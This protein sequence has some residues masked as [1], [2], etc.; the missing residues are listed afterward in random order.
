MSET[1]WKGRKLHFVGVGGSGMSGYARAAHT[2]GADVSGSD[3]ALTP[4][5][6]LLREEGVLDP[7]IS[8]HAA[9]VPAGEEVGASVHARSCSRSSPRCVAR[10]PWRAPTA[11]RRPPR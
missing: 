5:L 9:N 7:S 3:K 10:S 8:H 1:S 11:R 6:A 2:L 4:Y